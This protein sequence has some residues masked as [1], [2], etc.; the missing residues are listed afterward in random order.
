M[1]GF[2]FRSV[3]EIDFSP[4]PPSSHH[5][6]IR[7]FSRMEGEGRVIAPSAMQCIPS[8]PIPFQQQ[9]AVL[10]TTTRP[11]P[12]PATLSSLFLR[13]LYHHHPHR[14]PLY[15]LLHLCPCG[16]KTPPKLP[17]SPPDPHHAPHNTPMP[18]IYH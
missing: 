6:G 17:F 12:G 8:H 1:F 4:L 18:R 2:Y 16:L 3:V 13:F 9:P 15:P 14:P 5:A 10:R 11:R 7:V